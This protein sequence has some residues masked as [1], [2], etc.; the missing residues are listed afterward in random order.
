M[1][2]TNSYC[3]FRLCRRLFFPC[4]LD[5]LTGRVS[6]S[7]APDEP[8]GWLPTITSQ[9]ANPAASTT[10]GSLS[11]HPRR[12]I[13]SNNLAPTWTELNVPPA[14]CPPRTSYLAHLLQDPGQGYRPGDSYGLSKPWGFPPLSGEPSSKV[15]WQWEYLP[16]CLLWECPN[17]HCGGEP[18]INHTNH[19]FLWCAK[20]LIIH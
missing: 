11:I 19:K 1:P 12:S 20:N 7:K 2:P 10:R 5:G 9:S 4:S 18:V 17:V 6:G 8:A 15:W 3:K 16:S 14:V 13:Q